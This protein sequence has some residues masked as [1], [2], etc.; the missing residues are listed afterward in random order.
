VAVALPDFAEPSDLDDYRSGDD[1]AALRQAQ[2]RIRR[3]CGWHI[4]PEVTETITL[5][6]TG[7]SSLWLPSLY[8]T[9]IASITVEGVLESADNYDWSA[10]GYVNARYGTWS[11]RP[12]Q[13]VVEL[14]HGY[15]DIPDELVEVAV[16]MAAR[17]TASPGGPKRQTV[18]PFSVEWDIPGPLQHER[19][20]LDLFKLPPRP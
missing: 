4:A 1:A 3:Y 8:V 5:D 7:S 11:C 13:I 18:G 17:G 6:G 9:D 16:A 15:A 2:G 12:R 14:T 19:D 20:I 10:N